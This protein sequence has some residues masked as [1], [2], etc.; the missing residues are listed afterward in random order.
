MNHTPFKDIDGKLR[1][2]MKQFQTFIEINLP[3]EIYT[4]DDIFTDNSGI[5]NY[6]QIRST[7]GYV[8]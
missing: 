7:V 2:K 4:R 1:G 3:A 5:V 6:M 8:C